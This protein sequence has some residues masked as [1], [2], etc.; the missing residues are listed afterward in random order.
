MIEMG[1]VRDSVP[2][3]ISIMAGWPFRTTDWGHSL[4]TAPSLTML[5]ES[6]DADA[7]LA[8]RFRFPSAADASR[9]VTDTLGQAYGLD[10]VS[11]DRLV[12][13]ATNLLG[14]IQSADGP[15]LVKCCALPDAHTQL[16]AQGELLG[17]LRERE[18]PVSAPVPSRSGAVQVDREHLTLG[19]QRMIPGTWLDPSVSAQAGAA[20][21]VLADLHQ[22]LAGYPHAD[23]VHRTSAPAK[24]EDAVG[25]SLQEAGPVEPWRESA[26]RTLLRGIDGLD[27]S[28]LGIQLVHNDFRA[29]NILWH[30]NRIAA[31]LDFESL[32]NAYRIDD[33]AKTLVFLATI[34]HHWGPATP[35][36]HAAFLAGYQ[37]RQPL[38]DQE[39]AWLPTLILW[40]TIGQT[41]PG[42]RYQAW[43]DSIEYLS[44]AI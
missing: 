39:Q 16:L 34:F 41:R 28:G 5:W 17:W 20:G 27:S 7:A 31:V 25:K 8:Q 30:D 32:Q 10:V 21:E 6:T 40:H 26:I 19:V 36:A 2:K 14:F 43:L 12:I 9:W 37:S 42:P 15:L 13:S 4:T 35:A 3:P 24:L 23:D 22:A 33:L 1:F 44:A 11:V 18:I 29:A 38:T